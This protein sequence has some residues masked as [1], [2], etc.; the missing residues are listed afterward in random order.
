M[1]CLWRSNNEKNETIR[2][3]TIDLEALDVVK[4]GSL[5]SRGH[6]SWPMRRYALKG[7]NFS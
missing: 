6:S 4:S 3:E 2:C 1:W 5:D 7:K